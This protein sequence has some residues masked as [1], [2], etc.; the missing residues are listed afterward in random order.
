MYMSINKKIKSGL[1]W[2]FVN[3]GGNQ[4]IQFVISIVLA[5]L[6]AP[7]EFGLI[8]MVIFFT[9]FADVFKNLGMGAALIQK[10]DVDDRDYSTVFWLYLGLGFLLFTIF[11]LS[12]GIIADFYENSNLVS[13]TR[14]MS[15]SFL[16]SA[17]TGVPATI[18]LKK[19]NFRLR[20]KISITTLLIGPI[21]SF[22]LAYWG[23]GA[24]AIVFASL[25]KEIFS[26]IY[27]W[28]TVK[29]YPKFIFSKEKFKS[30]FKFGGLASLN[31]IL[32]YVYR[33][34]DNLI[35]GRMVGEQGLGLYS[36]AYGLMMLPISRISESVKT[37]LFP[38]L[39]QIKENNEKMRQIY[40]RSIRSTAFV[41]FPLMFGLSFIAEPFVLF[42]Y[43]SQW[44][45][46]IPILKILSLLGAFQSVKTFNGT[47]IY[48]KGK[49]LLDTKIFLVTVPLF[50]CAFIWGAKWNGIYGVAICY[51]GVSFLTM[52]YEIYL[53]LKLIDGSFL[54]FLK[55]LVPPL[56]FSL[57]MLLG[58]WIVRGCLSVYYQ[59]YS[60]QLLVEVGVGVVIYYS[61]NAIFKPKVYSEFLSL[62]KKKY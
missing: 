4:V 56:V 17:F 3:Q 13:L 52:W 35:I 7:S 28:L 51:A 29:W 55:N 6:I 25:V 59:G 54:F 22:P 48:A 44:Q 5:R 49:L 36:R 58:L 39:S 40:Y 42:V 60:V 31:G 23:Y 33:N 30:L 34:V 62:I 61:A 46:M 24:Y 41:V 57:V 21:V 15:I 43:G 8:S 53:T 47:I 10:S 1:F 11:F 2:V 45:G 26:A 38:A 50:I 37:V 14:L 12:A 9:G 32:F 18:V 16:I 20:T 27:Y 19:M